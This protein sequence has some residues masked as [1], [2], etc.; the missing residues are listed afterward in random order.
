MGLGVRDKNQDRSRMWYG[1]QNP[2]CRSRD[3]I[4][5]G[6][7]SDLLNPAMAFSRVAWFVCQSCLCMLWNKSLQCHFF[8]GQAST[9]CPGLLGHAFH[10]GLYRKPVHFR[11]NLLKHFSKLIEGSQWLWHF[12]TKKI[13]TQIFMGR[14]DRRTVSVALSTVWWALPWLQAH[15]QRSLTPVWKGWDADYIGSCKKSY[16]KEY[17]E[18][19]TFPR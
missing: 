18:V 3:P 2:S 8:L 13:T 5:V 6:R 1:A 9:P 10:P 17:M 15:I 4:C 16:P 7:H 14:K 11:Q 12:P 19:N